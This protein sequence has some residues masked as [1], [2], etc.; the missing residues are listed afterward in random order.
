[1]NENSS[2]PHDQI[3]NIV[4]YKPNPPQRILIDCQGKEWLGA[5]SRLYSM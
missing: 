5:N 3:N 4:N 2:H 1:M